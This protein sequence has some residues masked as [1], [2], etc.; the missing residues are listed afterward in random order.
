MGLNVKAPPLDLSLVWGGGLLLTTNQR[1]LSAIFLSTNRCIGT[2][3]RQ[4]Q[5]KNR[6]KFLK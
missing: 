2:K 1:F 3:I 4:K 6:R 5:Q